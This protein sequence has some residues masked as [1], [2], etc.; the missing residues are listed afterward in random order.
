ML[1]TGYN[2]RDLLNVV[3]MRPIFS[4]T[5]YIQIK[6]RGTRT[7]TFR[8]GGA[9]YEKKFYFLLD[10]CG[11]AAYFE[12]EYD[13]SI[14]LPLP[15]A[16]AE[17]AEATPVAG[18]AGATSAGKR[19]GDGQQAGVA[20]GGETGTPPRPG[21]PVW[22]GRD[23]VISE[24]VRIIGPEGE[25]V[26]VMTFRGSFERDVREF[27]ARDS[28][29]REAVDEQDDD[30]V[31]TILQERFFHRP[32]MYYSADKLVTAY[33]VPAP[34]P[35]FVYGALG[36]R[37]LPSR[38]QVIDDTVDSIAA[39][40]NL[41]YS[42]QRWL[43]ATAQLIA[44]DPLAYRKFIEGDFTLFGASQFNRLGGLPALA[45]FGA[46]DQVFDALRQSS[47][48]KQSSLQQ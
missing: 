41:R 9:E 42:E 4:P 48:V 1:S 33:G 26:D 19:G 16:K 35:A 46:R 11:V 6:G 44:D 30:A 43:N 40:F 25:K 38:D 45:A 34:T 10:F 8:V 18:G 27:T 31:E 32:E 39:Q 36:K 13:Y 21:I 3:L 23:V 7:F 15:R 37:P 5:E 22:E 28:D 47:L 17:G 29:F 2:C 14:P 12:E 20:A 24:D